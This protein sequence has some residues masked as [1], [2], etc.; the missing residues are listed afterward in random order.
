MIRQLLPVSALLLGS[1]LLL[2]AGGMNSL[3]LPIRGTA[4]GFSAASLGLLGTG[5]ALGYVAGCILTPPLVG[6]VG[7]I[8]AFSVMSAFAAVAMLLSLLILS[9]YAWIPLRA[10]SGFCFAGAAMIVESWLSERADPSSRGRIFGL[11]TMVNLIA[12]TAGQLVLTL[13][14]AT[15]ILFFILPAIFYCLALVPT[16][17]STTA[18]PKPL[19]NVRLDLRAL[20]RNSPVAV[21]GVFCVGISNSAFGTLAAVYA[22]RVGLAVTSVALFASLPVLA[23]AVSQIPIG[24]LSD[25][26]DRRVVLVGVVAAALA[27]DLVFIFLRPE[28]LGLNLILS[29]SFGAAIFAMYPIIVAH[30]NDHAAEGMAIQVSGGLLMVYGLGSIAGPTLAG[31]GMGM[32][33][34]AGLFLTSAGAHLL[35]IA[36]AILRIA[37]R[38]PVEDA[39]K[40]VFVPAPAAR[41]STPETAALAVGEDDAP[42]EEER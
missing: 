36:F 39:D 23:G 2:F 16:A 22:D 7:H 26:M 42:A 30:A 8:R 11:Y 21:F 34:G 18:M 27:V 32:L 6:K 10:L 24:W 9:P 17:M 14:D 31:V 1:A 5:W 33:G 35:L 19:V 37:Q 13:G 20:W 25:R 40:G 12:S 3:I 38:A 4:E 41:A 28:A 29:A 15:G